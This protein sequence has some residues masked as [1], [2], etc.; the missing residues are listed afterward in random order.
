[1]QGQG[2]GQA[3][4]RICA[5]LPAEY[6]RIAQDSRVRA[7]GMSDSTFTALPAPPSRHMGVR[8]LS[9]QATQLS[10]SSAN[11]HCRVHPLTT[12]RAKP[13]D[14]RAAFVGQPILHNK[15]YAARRKI[16][17]Q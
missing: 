13:K 4:H 2:T 11:Q 12:P 3:P 7:Q 15:D 8:Y 1:M 10:F 14:Y 6:L 5:L 17:M 9:R 16:A